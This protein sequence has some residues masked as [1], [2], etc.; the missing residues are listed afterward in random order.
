MDLT[1]EIAIVRD[2]S[3]KLQ[4]RIKEVDAYRAD[5]DSKEVRV[6]RLYEKFNA[7]R[8]ELEKREVEVRAV[9][10]IIRLKIDA[11]RQLKEAAELQ[12]QIQ[13]DREELDQSKKSLLEEKRKLELVA[14]DLK[15][16]QDNLARD[17]KQFNQQK[18]DLKKKMASV[19]VKI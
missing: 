2:L 16:E 11:E 12:K 10:D 4:E 5:I 3:I 14:G 13:T 19:N 1:K 15:K 17:W 18:A 7:E 6:N 8:K 9:E